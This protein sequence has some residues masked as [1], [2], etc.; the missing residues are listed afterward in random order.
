MFP[1]AIVALLKL[2]TL[3]ATLILLIAVPAVTTAVPDATLIVEPYHTL[4][5][6]LIAAPAGRKM[7]ESTTIPTE[8]PAGTIVK[9]VV[10]CRV[11]SIP[12]PA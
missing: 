6:P 10:F 4:K 3:V 8:Y 11:L 1:L 12:Q 7:I 9:P 5:V 2:E